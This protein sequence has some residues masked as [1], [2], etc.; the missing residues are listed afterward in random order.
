[1]SN[2][3]SRLHGLDVLR[4]AAI[5]AV[6]LFHYQEF[7][8]H[9]T[10]MEAPFGLGYLG[11]DL[12]F[13]LSAYLITSQLLAELDRSQ[14]LDLKVFYIKRS[15]RILPPFLFTLLVYVSFP[16]ARETESLA[17][18]YRYLTFTQ[19]FGLDRAVHGTFSH[20]WSLCV[21]EHYYLV[22]PVLL[23]FVRPKRLPTMVGGLVLA[24]LILR[25]LTFHFAVGNQ[26]NPE[27][28]F[29]A[30]DRWIYRPTQCRMDGLLIGALIAWFFRYQP[31]VRGWLVRK[32]ALC[33]VSSV[34]V[35]GLALATIVVGGLFGLSLLGFPLIA[36]AFGLLVINA[37]SPASVM[38]RSDSPLIGWIATLSYS[39][40]LCHKITIHVTQSTLGGMGL[41]R[42]G[43]P[44]FAACVVSTVALSWAM[45][46]LIER[47]ALKLRRIVLR[48]RSTSK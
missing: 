44:M 6:F 43:L 40:Y 29:L 27:A 30:F 45:H 24:G 12:F 46:M 41:A 21:E 10:W 2:K 48:T 4:A 36:V 16:W 5:I 39:A 47:P 7:F 37:V 19:N 11:V 23:I 22:L 25:G 13:V 32:H 8:E 35:L 26:P 42:D 17:P 38:F 33:M 15:I 34:V 14:R 31:A 28:E 3:S 20:A 9:P 1:M 18:V